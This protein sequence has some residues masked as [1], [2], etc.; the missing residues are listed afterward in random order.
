MSKILCKDFRAFL[1][2]CGFCVCVFFSESP[3][4]VLMVSGSADLQVNITVILLVVV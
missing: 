1:R 2:Y 3:C 4:S